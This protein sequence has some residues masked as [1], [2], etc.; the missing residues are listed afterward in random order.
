MESEVVLY[1]KAGV[2]SKAAA[3][4]AKEAGYV[5]VGEYSG[6]WMDWERNGMG[7]EGV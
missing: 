3:G 4:M 7:Q 6:S 2:R 1:C 5:K